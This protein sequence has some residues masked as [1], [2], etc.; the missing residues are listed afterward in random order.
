MPGANAG[1]DVV[2]LA[3]RGEDHVLL[4]RFPAGFEREQVGSYPVAETFLVVRGELVLEQ[5]RHGPGTLVHVPARA[6]RTDLRTGSGAT[7]L[8]WFSGAPVFVPGRLEAVDWP[9]RA[10]DLSSGELGPSPQGE[11]LRTPE[12]VWTVQATSIGEHVDLDTFRW[13][14]HAEPAGSRLLVRQR[15][16]A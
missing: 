15:C 13:A 11:V 12:A 14:L 9:V 6:I 3:S 4:T 7:A 16:Q 1:I 10:V 8:A 5:V 2:P